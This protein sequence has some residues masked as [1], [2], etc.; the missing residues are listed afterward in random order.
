MVR[1]VNCVNSLKKL[2]GWTFRLWTLINS[3]YKKGKSTT[4]LADRF[5]YSLLDCLRV[6]RTT[7]T[8]LIVVFV[9]FLVYTKTVTF[10]LTTGSKLQKRKRHVNEEIKQRAN[11]AKRVGYHQTKIHSQCSVYVFLCEFVFKIH[12]NETLKASDNILCFT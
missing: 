7:K 2:I 1:Q 5:I 11:I 9:F 12:K 10:D 8:V 4:V 3:Q 6:N